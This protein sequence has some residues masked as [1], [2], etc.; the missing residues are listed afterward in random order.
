MVRPIN[1]SVRR[2]YDLEKNGAV[3]IDRLGLEM[4]SRAKSAKQLISWSFNPSNSD[5]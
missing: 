5:V 1:F 3:Q 4:R 2:A